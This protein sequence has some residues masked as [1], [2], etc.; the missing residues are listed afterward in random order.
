MIRLAENNEFVELLCALDDALIERDSKTI[1]TLIHESSPE[2]RAEL[3][4]A[5]PYLLR[6]PFALLAPFSAVMVRGVHV[7]GSSGWVSGG[8]KPRAHQCAAPGKSL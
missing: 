5:A 8:T 4:Q 2:V 1:E 6:A 7:V 3:E